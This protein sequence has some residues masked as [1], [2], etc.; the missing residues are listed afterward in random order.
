MT[1]VEGHP[2]GK[3]GVAPLRILLSLLL[4][5]A[6]AAAGPAYRFR[7]DPAASQVS[8]RVSYFGLGHKTA[9]FPVL[10]GSIRLA[11][12]RL[13]AIDLEVDLD[14]RNMTAGGKTDTEYLRGKAFFDVG[15][16]PVVRFAGKRM[17]MT[18]AQTARVE[19][20]ITARGITRPA[21]LSVTFAQ[22][23]VRASGREP[24]ELTATT[25]L[26]RRD[27]GMTSYGLVV[28]KNVT[29]TIRARLMPD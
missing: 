2:F 27:F 8:A 11:P 21:V 29:V 10:R 3:T 7:I 15:N 24:I 5:L 14:A 18:G 16:Y 13:D 26:N 17:E 22:P 20:Q 1:A 19:G 23:P 6:T 4:L 28:G 25:K 12:D 9:M